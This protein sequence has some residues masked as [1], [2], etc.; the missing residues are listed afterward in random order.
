MATTNCKYYK[1]EQE[2]P[3]PPESFKAVFWE[4]ER[5]W[6]TAMETH[7]ATMLEQYTYFCLDDHKIKDGVAM[8]LKA[9]ILNWHY[10]HGGEYQTAK[11]CI[12]LSVVNCFQKL[13]SLHRE[14]TG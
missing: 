6:Q 1:G 10:Q 4:C 11:G 13:V 14:T 5:R 3:F 12:A 9:E 2:N 7:K 8:S